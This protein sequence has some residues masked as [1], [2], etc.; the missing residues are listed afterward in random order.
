MSKLP[1]GGTTTP[2]HTR[3]YPTAV[4][5]PECHLLTLDPGHLT[6]DSGLR[7]P[8]SAPESHI[9]AS[10]AIPHSPILTDCKARVENMARRGG[11]Q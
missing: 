6:I 3:T 4:T 2:F 10:R 11:F 8:D 9:L 7:T 1:V 5:A